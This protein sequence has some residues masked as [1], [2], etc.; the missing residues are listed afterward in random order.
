MSAL[1]ETAESIQVVKTLNDINASTK[2]RIQNM[3]N[4][5]S[6]KDFIDE[7]N[8]FLDGEDISELQYLLEDKDTKSSLKLEC[9]YG[10]EGQGDQYYMV[11]VWNDQFWHIPGWYSSYAGGEYQLDESVEVMPRLVVKT[12]YHTL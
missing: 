7:V 12:E 8:K 3:P 2:N 9:Q 6:E 11:I 1:E 5:K 10:G 4:R